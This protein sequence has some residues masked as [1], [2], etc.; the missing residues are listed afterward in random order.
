L[1]YFRRLKIGYARPKKKHSGK[2]A[3]APLL[4]CRGL[5]MKK[6]P[7][8]TGFIGG[9]TRKSE[10][11]KIRPNHFRKTRPGPIKSIKAR[12]HTKH[13]FRHPMAWSQR[14]CAAD[15]RG[16]D[17]SIIYFEHGGKILS[18]GFHAF[19]NLHFHSG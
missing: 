11:A 9:W 7:G 2:S 18:P 15:L 4:S 3:I 17:K 8:L 5:L 19:Q 13:G 14:S 10:R 1:Y 12:Q 16:K 6:W